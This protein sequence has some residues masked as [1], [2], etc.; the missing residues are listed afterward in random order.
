[1]IALIK[2]GECIAIV[3]STD[4]HDLD[5]VTVIDAPENPTEWRYQA[6]AWV[7]RPLTEVE[8]DEETLAGDGRWNAVRNATPA[9]IEAWLAANVTSLADARAVLKTLI[10][11]A[12]K[13]ERSK[14]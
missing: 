5:G 7:P 13:L 2:D 1:M 8:Q 12:R 9:Q 14:R 10:L 4:G 3:H 6:G 11:A